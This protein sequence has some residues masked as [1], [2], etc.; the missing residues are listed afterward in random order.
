MFSI[1]CKDYKNSPLVWLILSFLSFSSFGLSESE[2]GFKTAG[3]ADQRVQYREVLSQK[4]WS[5]FENDKFDS[6]RVDKNPA[7]AVHLALADKK[8]PLG[9][10]SIESMG[11]SRRPARKKAK[12]VRLKKEGS[13]SIPVVKTKEQ[14]RKKK[15]LNLKAVR[16]PTLSRVYYETGNR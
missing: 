10:K 11:L 15:K 14:R 7:D 2:K 6:N 12:R 9:E 13:F 8:A 16:P 1:F 4:R 3:K 5:V